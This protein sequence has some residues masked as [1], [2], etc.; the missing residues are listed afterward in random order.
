MR[1]KVAWSVLLG[2]A[3]LGLIA[4]GTARTDA[5]S[6]PRPVKE[7]TRSPQAER[8]ESNR[9]LPVQ[10]SATTTEG[11]VVTEEEAPEIFQA[12]RDH[13]AG[14]DRAPKETKVQTVETAGGTLTIVEKGDGVIHIVA[15]TINRENPNLEDAQGFAFSAAISREGVDVSN[16]DREHLA[17]LVGEGQGGIAST[18]MEGGVVDV[19]MECKTV[20]GVT[21]CIVVTETQFC[22]CTFG[23]APLACQCV[24]LVAA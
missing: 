5:Q 16:V 18:T 7:E 23:G 24:K 9:D 15:F 4:I 8:V 17:R 12:L 19:A 10:Q 14:V 22:V 13:L 21:T 3:L 2:S 1:H 20:G 6:D 11:R